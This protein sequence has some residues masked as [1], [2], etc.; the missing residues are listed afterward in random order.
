[1]DV[2]RTDVLDANKSRAASAQAKR[3]GAWRAWLMPG[4][5]QV[6]CAGVLAAI[7]AFLIMC[8]MLLEREGF[9]PYRSAS[10]WLG[11]LALGAL[12]Y[13]VIAG[14]WH[15]L[16][17]RRASRAGVAGGARTGAG[18]GTDAAAGAGAASGAALQG[19]KSRKHVRAA[20]VLVAVV[21][22]CTWL[23]VWPGYFTY[24]T[25]AFVTFVQ[26][27]TL[28]NQQSVIHTLFVGTVLKVGLKLFGSWNAAIALYVGVQL[29]IVLFTI[30]QILRCVYARSRGSV[31]VWLTASFFAFNPM[32]V[33]HM[34]C[35]TKDIVFSCALVLLLM[36]IVALGD[37][38]EASASSAPSTHTYHQHTSR[39]LSSGFIDIIKLGGYAFVAGAYRNNAV[40][41]LVV[42]LLVLFAVLSRRLPGRRRA[43]AQKLLPLALGGVLLPVIFNGPVASALG[44]Q[45]ANALREMIAQPVS[46]IARVAQRGGLDLGELE[47]RGIDGRT[48]VAH[49]ATNGKHNSD[50]TR[51]Y[52]WPLLESRAGLQSFARLWLEAVVMHPATSLDA[53]FELTRAA[54]VPGYIVDAYQHTDLFGYNQWPSS[55]FAADVEDPGT[56]TPL[57]PWVA[58]A[59]YVLMH[60]DAF[61]RW[62]WAL[63][64]SPAVYVWLLLFALAR[65]VATKQQVYAAGAILLLALVGTNLLGPTVLVRYYVPLYVAAPVLLVLMGRPVG[66][67]AAGDAAGAAGVTAGAEAATASETRSY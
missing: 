1:M 3:S 36:E 39:F 65:F 5:R 56:E 52:F 55:Y 29:I 8:N 43:A 38:S 12:F 47:R 27:G 20:L 30:Y 34:L 60:S 59:L 14:I 44:V 57:V 40:P 23:A 41:V 19:A 24:D 53:S 31:A 61:A 32:V 67:W 51:S 62:P 21:Y 48:V 45:K 17:V 22:V 9:I 37:K 7:Y 46:Q 66:T 18:A 6:A 11:T 4:R 63:A 49:Y 64:G 26:E 10:L 25:G 28:T 15:V 58:R 33:V 16:D 50:S 2:R 54:L 42:A 35:T 13:L